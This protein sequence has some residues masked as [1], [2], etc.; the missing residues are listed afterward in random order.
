LTIKGEIQRKRMNYGPIVLT[1]FMIQTIV[2]RKFKERG[3]KTVKIL[4]FLSCF[5]F[6][7]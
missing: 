6:I 2:D 3:D 1:G 5:S 4:F 7:F